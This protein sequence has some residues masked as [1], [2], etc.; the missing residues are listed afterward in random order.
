MS[1]IEYRLAW[2]RGK[3]AVTWSEDG[4]R[5][6]RSL[7]TADQATAKALLAEFVKHR[8]I[9]QDG[10]PLTV[11]AIYLAYE[12]DRKAEGKAVSRIQD[13]WKRL[14]PA[15]G[16]LLPSYITKQTCRDYISSRKA[17]RGT[18]HL[19]LTY[20]RAALRYAEKEKWLTKAPHIYVPTRPK[21]RDH[22]LTKPEALKL[23]EAAATHHLRLFI[24]LALATAARASALLELKWDQ[25]DM[26]RRTIDLRDPH[27][28]ETPKGRAIVPINDMAFQALEQAAK[29]RLTDNVIEFAGRPVESVKKGVSAA[30][31]RAGI[32]AT[33]HVLRHSAAVWMAEDG[34]K[35]E[36]IA[37]FLGHTTSATT[38]RVY[39]RYSPEHLRKASKALEL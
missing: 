8:A 4:Q 25:V 7:G 28:A 38:Y 5:F 15:F 14:A 22:Y 13:A 36:E 24:T 21:P 23:I 11:A 19:E 18:V 29:V 17:S 30:A 26:K 33:P 27:K 35:M 37:Q 9:T 39:A 6:R 20:L 34:V 31:A 10:G 1:E 12:G 3:L 32:K 16:T 2:H